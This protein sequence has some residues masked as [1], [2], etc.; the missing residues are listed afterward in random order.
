M[1]K[2]TAEHRI[3]ICRR[4]WLP[5]ASPHRYRAKTY[6]WCKGDRSAKHTRAAARSRVSNVGT[7]WALPFALF[8]TLYSCKPSKA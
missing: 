3:M 4:V 6:L 5:S 8:K 1:A 2:A 7:F